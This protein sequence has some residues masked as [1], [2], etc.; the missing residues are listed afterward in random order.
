MTLARK[1]A[2][3]QDSASTLFHQLI[4]KRILVGLGIVT[5]AAVFE[6]PPHQRAQLPSALSICRNPDTTT[7]SSPFIST[8]SGLQISVKDSFGMGVPDSFQHGPEILS[9]LLVF[10]TILG[11]CSYNDVLYKGIT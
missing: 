8:F 6:W 5:L 1:N 10:P 3:F 9:I 7:S 4:G 11:N 2:I